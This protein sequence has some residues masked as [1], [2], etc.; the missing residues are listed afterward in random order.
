MTTL[1]ITSAGLLITIIA[2]VIALIS[3]KNEVEELQEAYNR[4][5]SEKYWRPRYEI[6]RMFVVV[7]NDQLRAFT[8]QEIQQAEAEGYKYD[9]QES[10]PTIL[11]FKKYVPCKDEDD[12]PSE[13]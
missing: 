9:V 12:Q 4:L 2:L 11:C 6:L 1:I 7:N 10:F 8:Q 3:K 13:S 5:Q